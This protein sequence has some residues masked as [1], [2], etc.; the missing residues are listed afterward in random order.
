VILNSFRVIL[1][2]H[3]TTAPIS[4]T[5]NFNNTTKIPP[6]EAEKKPASEQPAGKK[7]KAVKNAGKRKT[8]TE[9]YSIYIFRK[10][11]KTHTNNNGK[12]SAC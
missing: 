9:S 5:S 4:S 8:R 2:N 6:K 10:K 3:I 7:P 11:E 12:D 1:G